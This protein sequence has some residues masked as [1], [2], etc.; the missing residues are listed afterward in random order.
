LGSDLGTPG[1]QDN[2]VWHFFIFYFLENIFW[3][4][5]RVIKQQ[6]FQGWAFCQLLKLVYETLL[7]SPILLN[8]NNWLY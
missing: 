8:R 7:A 5:F 2:R 4:Q 3:Q 6:A 1:F